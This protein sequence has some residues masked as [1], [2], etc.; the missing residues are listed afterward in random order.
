[1][2]YSSIR[3]ETRPDLWSNPTL[4][5]KCKMLKSLAGFPVGMSRNHANQTTWE[6]K[7]SYRTH[8]SF[9]QTHQI[10]LQKR[11]VMYQNK[12]IPFRA[13]TW[14][15][16]F[17]ISFTYWPDSDTG[18]LITKNMKKLHN[19]H[20]R[21]ALHRQEVYNPDFPTSTSPHHYYD[22]H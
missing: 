20:F 16:E 19:V 14:I 6:T 1:M 15:H 18:M 11:P 3:K 8:W 17:I 12:I 5:S 7:M 22:G 9:L 13:G 4:L 2:H 10:Q 21:V